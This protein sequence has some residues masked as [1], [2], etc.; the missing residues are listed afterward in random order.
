[1]LKSLQ[2]LK[3]PSPAL[4]LRREYN[5]LHATVDAKPVEGS[6]TEVVNTGG[7]FVGMFH[8]NLFSTL[9]FADFFLPLEW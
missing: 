4:V 1:M 3:A 2:C 6:M 8:I 9:Y 5:G 7:F